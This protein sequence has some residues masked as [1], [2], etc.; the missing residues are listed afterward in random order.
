MDLLDYSK[1]DMIL[2]NEIVSFSENR[3]SSEPFESYL[4]KIRLHDFVQ[5]LGLK[6]TMTRGKSELKK[7]AELFNELVVNG[8]ITKCELNFHP[9]GSEYYR[10]ES[11]LIEIWRHG[12]FVKER[13]RQLK[14]RRKG[15]IIKVISH[16]IRLPLP[17]AIEWNWVEIQELILNLIGVLSQIGVWVVYLKIKAL[18]LMPNACPFFH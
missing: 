5:A 14:E 18:L 7:C 2:L 12:G 11:R 13:K 16:I 15:R 3:L 1:Q 10:N 17:L 8:L 4:V 6:S 9:N